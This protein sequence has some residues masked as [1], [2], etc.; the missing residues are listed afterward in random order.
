MYGPVAAA[1]AVAAHLWLRCSEKTLRAQV[2]AHLLLLLA[3]GPR[4]QL[5]HHH[6]L[7]NMPACTPALHCLYTHSHCLSAFALQACPACEQK[8]GKQQGAKRSAIPPALHMPNN[9]H[10]LAMAAYK[11]SASLAAAHLATTAK[12][13][14]FLL[15]VQLALKTAC[16]L[17]RRCR[18]LHHF[19]PRVCLCSPFQ[20]M[21][22]HTPG[23]SSTVPLSRCGCRVCCW[24]RL[25]ALRCSV[26]RRLVPRSS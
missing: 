21:V 12:E 17:H 20:S 15:S 19:R 22:G 5:Y 3:A 14:L 2:P 1:R 25:G 7:A 4:D 16:C 6:F 13:R 18:T 11:Q 24:L 23:S 9:P 26:G 10:S 8:A